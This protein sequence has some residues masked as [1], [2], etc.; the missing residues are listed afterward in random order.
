MIVKTFRSLENSNDFVV[1]RPDNSVSRVP[2]TQCTSQ[3]ISMYMK[4][5]ERKYSATHEEPL[6]PPEITTSTTVDSETGDSY[7]I[8]TLTYPDPEVEDLTLEDYRSSL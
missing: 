2:M 3:I 4:R 1:F 6:T 8:F 7:V 5:V